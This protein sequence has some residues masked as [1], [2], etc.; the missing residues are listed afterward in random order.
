MGNSTVNCG[1]QRDVRRWISLFTTQLATGVWLDWCWPQA[2]FPNMNAI[3]KIH[4]TPSKSAPSTKC[5]QIACLW[6]QPSLF[7]LAVAPTH[8]NAATLKPV[9]S[10]L[11]QSLTCHQDEGDQKWQGHMSLGDGHISKHQ[12]HLQTRVMLVAGITTGST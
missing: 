12:R 8:G 4:S 10:H 5:S 9:I 7:L 11:Y 6:P 1:N 2:V 3:A